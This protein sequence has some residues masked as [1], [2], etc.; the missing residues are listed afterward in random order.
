TRADFFEQVRGDLPLDPPLIGS[1][2]WDALADSLWGG[3][4][5]AD[6]SVV[7]IIWK[8][9]SDLRRNAPEDF[10]IAM[11]VF[12]DLASSLAK[13]EDTDGEPKKVCVY[14]CCRNAIEVAE[15]RF[16]FWPAVNGGNSAAASWS[17]KHSGSTSDTP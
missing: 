7:A 17:V 16:V 12:R 6:A 4:D 14:V 9:A 8:G 1:Q 11:S 5:S 15:S 10:A 3:I 13:W 2:S